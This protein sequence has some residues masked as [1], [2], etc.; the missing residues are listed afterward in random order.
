SGNGVT[1]ISAMLD[2]PFGYGRIIRDGDSLA[3]TV[4]DVKRMVIKRPCR[5]A[6]RCAAWP[7]FVNHN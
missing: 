4:R 1:V 6:K 5:I 3:K 7:Y 2:D